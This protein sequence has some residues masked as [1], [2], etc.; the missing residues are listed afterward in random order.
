MD[1]KTKEVEAMHGAGKIVRDLL[2][3]TRRMRECGATYMPCFSLMPPD[4]HKNIIAKA[5]LYPALSETLKAMTGRVFFRGVDTGNVKAN[6]ISA[7]FGDMDLRNRDLNT[8]AADWF[9][10]ALAFGVSY[11]LVDYQNAPR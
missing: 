1:N 4:M 5:T 2:G 8:I 11:M 9:E 6:A 3:G 7:L 10:D